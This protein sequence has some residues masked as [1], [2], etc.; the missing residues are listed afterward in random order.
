MIAVDSSSFI[1]FFKEDAAKD[2]QWISDA[3]ENGK[4]VLPPPV[5]TE[6]L[7][8]SLLPKHLV[9]YIEALPL[10]PVFAGLWSRAGVMR[11]K[12]L[13]KKLKARL[14]DTLIAQVCIDHGVPLI[15]RDNDFRH[16]VTHAGLVLFEG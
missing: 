1:A 11:S 9:E 7:S 10:L 16:F 15:T 12:L 5:L 13:A 14:A 2:V 3:L 4:L 6:V 8:N